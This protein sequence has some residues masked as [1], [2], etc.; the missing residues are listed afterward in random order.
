[1]EAARSS[2]ILV[3]YCNTTWHH[4]PEDLNLNEES[5]EVSKDILNVKHVEEYRIEAIFY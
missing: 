4:N 1:M 5:E 3:S 2:E